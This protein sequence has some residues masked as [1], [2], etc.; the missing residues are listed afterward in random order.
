MLAEIGTCLCI[1]QHIQDRIEWKVWKPWN[2]I[3]I[4]R[5]GTVF[6]RMYN[7]H[8]SLRSCL[9]YQIYLSVL[10]VPQINIFFAID[11]LRY[12][13]LYYY[14]QLLYLSNYNIDLI[15]FK[16]VAIVKLPQ[17]HII[18]LLTRPLISF[19]KLSGKQS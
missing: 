10:L 19:L 16:K 18:C 8:P 13:L 17:R 1:W 11:L 9:Y 12:P 4:I 14:C 15:T 2:I 7:I 6:E 5:S 3:S